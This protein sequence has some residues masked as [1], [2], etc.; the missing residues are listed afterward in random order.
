MPKPRCGSAQSAYDAA[1]SLNPA[2][3]GASPQALQLEQATNNYN[4]AKSA[5]D[6]AAKGADN[7]QIKAARSK[8]KMRAPT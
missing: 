3:I 8:L 7:A 2:G 1:D 6:K 4:A 5:Y